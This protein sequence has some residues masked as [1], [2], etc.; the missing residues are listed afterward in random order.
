MTKTDGPVFIGRL[1]EL[2]ELS[3]TP[4]STLRQRLYFEQLADL[5]LDRVL[6]ALDELARTSRFFPLVSEIRARAGVDRLTAT[7]VYERLV[8]VLRRSPLRVPSGLDPFDTFVIA[9][10]GGPHAFMAM[11]SWLLR[12]LC[13]ERV[14]EWL[15]VARVRGLAIPA[16]QVASSTRPALPAPE[17]MAIEG[18]V[19]PASE[20]PERELPADEALAGVRAML[21]R[22]GGGR[23]P[24]RAT[25]VE[26]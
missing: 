2:A 21:G 20:A 13:E 24:R 3:G 12:K 18:P 6:V 22:I 14:E 10:L 8:A 4:L 26:R 9:A 5:P 7:E 19:S 25:G 1:L 11:E 15:E 16:R 17:R 23:D